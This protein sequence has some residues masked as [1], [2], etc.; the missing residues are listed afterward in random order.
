MAPG[1]AR[2]KLC[3]DALDLGRCFFDWHRTSF[4]KVAIEIAHFHKMHHELCV[5]RLGIVVVKLNGAFKDLARRGFSM[6]AE[7]LSKESVASAAN[8]WKL[9]Y[10]AASTPPLP[11]FC[12]FSKSMT[13]AWYLGDR[14]FP[15]P[16]KLS[17]SRPPERLGDGAFP[18]LNRGFFLGSGEGVFVRLSHSISFADDG[19][20]LAS[21]ATEAFVAA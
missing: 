1:S 4:G 18:G 5:S 19:S 16:R 10:A 2:L 17:S 8:I 13:A 7:P 15:R 14:I 6:K 12:R 3:L 11:S 21:A 20:T 9:P